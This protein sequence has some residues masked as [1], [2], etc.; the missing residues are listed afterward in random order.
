V[1][2]LASARKVADAIVSTA[3]SGTQDADFHALTLIW[4]KVFWMIGP[5]V[6]GLIG[7]IAIG[8]AIVLR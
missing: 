8:C 5:Q 4:I 2:M 1:V 7:G 6:I 3:G